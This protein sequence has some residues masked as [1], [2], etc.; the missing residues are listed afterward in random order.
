MK[1]TECVAR[2][3]RVSLTNHFIHYGI[4]IK[5][6]ENGFFHVFD[7][8]TN[9]YLSR[10]WKQILRGFSGVVLHLSRL[11]DLYKSKGVTKLRGEV[12]LKRIVRKKCGWKL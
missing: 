7:L 8:S 5:V 10:A 9:F 3:N 4:S 1:Q 6:I 12:R 2:V 11:G